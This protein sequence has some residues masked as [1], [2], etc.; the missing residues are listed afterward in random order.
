[1]TSLLLIFCNMFEIYLNDTILKYG[2]TL[3]STSLLPRVGDTI[4]LDGKEYTV[5]KVI[6]VVGTYLNRVL[7][8]QVHVSNH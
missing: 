3:D 2:I 7:H 8:Y 1:M 4:Y 5:R 6:F